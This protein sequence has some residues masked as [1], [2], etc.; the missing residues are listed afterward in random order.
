MLR[1]GLSPWWLW[2]FGAVT[3][4]AGLLLWHR[5][6]PHFGLRRTVGKLSATAAYICLAVLV[7]LIV[8]GLAVDGK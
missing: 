8:L 4:P 7:G 5:L 1:Y 2:I 6:G 3:V